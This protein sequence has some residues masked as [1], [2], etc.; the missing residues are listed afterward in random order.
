MQGNMCYPACSHH[1]SSDVHIVE[2]STW[3]GNVRSERDQGIVTWLVAFLC[4]L[5]TLCVL[6]CALITSVQ[7]LFHGAQPRVARLFILRYIVHDDVMRAW[8][9]TFKCLL[10]SSP[11]T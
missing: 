3:S 4:C 1:K 10:L 7:M 8:L 5:C 2:G 6:Q 11:G 9:S